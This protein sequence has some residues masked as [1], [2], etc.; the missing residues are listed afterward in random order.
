MKTIAI[1]RSVKSYLPEIQIYKDF[2]TEYNFIEFC[3]DDELKGENIDLIW[4]FMGIDLKHMDIPVIHEYTSLSVGN[5]SCVKNY[6]KRQFNVK[7]SLR[8]YLNSY[9]CDGL[10]FD[11]DVPFC[12]RDMGI[13]TYFFDIADKCNSKEFDF[14]YVGS[15]SEAR[16]LM[17]L[18]EYIKNN[19]DFKLL[20]IGTPSI[21]LYKQYKNIKNIF[22]AGRLAY[23]DVAKCAIKAEYGINYIPDVYPFNIQTSTKLLEYV[24]LGLK[25]ITTSYSWVDEFEKRRGMKFFHMAENCS[26]LLSKNLEAFDFKNSDVKDLCWDNILH[27]SG[28]RERLFKL[29]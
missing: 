20:L 22:F 2:F 6:I 25:V 1:Q 16:N 8:I 19:S 21:E 29:I 3:K 28:I 15:M 14:V 27:N 23:E 26:N 24:A 10:A 18:L 9:V 12:F 5:F 7:P 13:D 11:D 17:F 4:R